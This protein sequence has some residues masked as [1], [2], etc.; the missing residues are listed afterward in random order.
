M[1]NSFSRVCRKNAPIRDNALTAYAISILHWAELIQG[2]PIN[3]LM[4][5]LFHLQDGVQ[6]D[7]FGLPVLARN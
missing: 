7:E 1:L 4:A 5:I 6:V 3:V 2:T